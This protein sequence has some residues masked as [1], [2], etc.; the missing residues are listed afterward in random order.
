MR[1]VGNLFE[2]MSLSF[3]FCA[4]KCIHEDDDDVDVD[5]FAN[6]LIIFYVLVKCG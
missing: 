1:W 3:F 5:D 6:M 2:Q 4:M